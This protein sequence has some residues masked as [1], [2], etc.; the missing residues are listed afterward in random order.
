MLHDAEAGSELRP[1]GERPREDPE[2]LPVAGADEEKVL[3]AAPLA[4]ARE[5]ESR[6][7]VEGDRVEF[8]EGDR[9]GLGW[10]AVDPDRSLRALRRV[11]DPADQI[12]ADR[13]SVPRPAD[14]GRPA[15][16]RVVRVIARG[17]SEEH[18]SELQSRE[19]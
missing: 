4:L 8:L 19:N 9:A 5:L 3:L 14:A 7:V 1:A 17:R 12:P 16:D 11:V 15:P 2:R 10:L 18:T 13:P 6:A